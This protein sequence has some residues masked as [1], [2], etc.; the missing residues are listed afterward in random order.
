MFFSILQS[1]HLVFTNLRRLNFKEN[2][3]FP[4]SETIY[5]KPNLIYKT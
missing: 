1:T 4:K 5:F 3:Y 2:K